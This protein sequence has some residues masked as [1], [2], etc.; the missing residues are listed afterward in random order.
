MKTILKWFGATLIFLFAVML[1]R[2]FTFGEGAVEVKSVPLLEIDETGFAE[3]FAGGLRVP[4]VAYTDRSKM[5]P[6]AFKAF[7]SY[8]E[9]NYPKVH[10][11]LKREIMGDLSLLTYGRGQTCRSILFY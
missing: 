1:I 3:R 11:Y 5:D 6:K 8:L 4:T 7:H 9:S 2:T 10:S